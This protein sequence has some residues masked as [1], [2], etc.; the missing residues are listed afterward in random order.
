VLHLSRFNCPVLSK[1]GTLSPSLNDTTRLFRSSSSCIGFWKLYPGMRMDNCRLHL[2]HFLFSEIAV[3]EIVLS[4][5]DLK[6][7][8]FF[9]KFPEFLMFKA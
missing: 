8:L 2:F 1:F 9:I 3:S 4:A 7:N 6:T 5:E